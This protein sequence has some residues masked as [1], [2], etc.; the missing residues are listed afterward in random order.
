MYTTTTT[1]TTTI[2]LLPQKTRLIYKLIIVINNMKSL[3]Y[4]SINRGI[5]MYIVQINAHRHSQYILH[6]VAI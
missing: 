3:Y 1:T 6:C 4:V 2:I 5:A